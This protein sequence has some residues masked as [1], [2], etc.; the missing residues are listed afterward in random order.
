MVQL[1]VCKTTLKSLASISFNHNSF[2]ISNYS[3]DSS[4]SFFFYS[5]IRLRLL[6]FTFAFAWK[7]LDFLKKTTR[8]GLRPDV[9]LS[10]SSSLLHIT[11]RLLLS[12]SFKL[13]TTYSIFLNPTLFPNTP[14]KHF[15]FHF[16]LTL[17]TLSN[18]LSNKFQNI[19]FIIQNQHESFSVISI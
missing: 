7:F 15:S 1:S 9:F 16:A 2:S 12:Q 6:R 14:K 11:Y 19:L 18:I 17:G 3:S 4:F 8:T 5:G 10:S 13:I